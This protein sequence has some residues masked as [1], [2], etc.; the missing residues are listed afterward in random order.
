M[1]IPPEGHAL[2]AEVGRPRHF[3]NFQPR[4]KITGNDFRGTNTLTIV[5]P[6]LAAG[7]LRLIVTN[8]D[9]ETTAVDTA[10]TAN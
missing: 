8:P 1:Y 9:G 4:R 10:F 6:A 2:L 3:A 7:A 5:A